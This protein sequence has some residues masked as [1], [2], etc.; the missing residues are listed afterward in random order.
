MV[1]TGNQ[2]PCCPCLILS[3]DLWGQFGDITGSE[4]TFKYI[5]VYSE[6]ST[7]WVPSQRMRSDGSLKLGFQ[8]HA[9]R[10]A[11]A[12]M[13]GGFRDSAL[14]DRF[15]PRGRRLCQTNCW[16]VAGV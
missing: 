15:D 13:V 11:P 6:A 3:S 4:E 9:H 5:E 1:A 7:Y 14:R 16:C 2:H 12:G 10:S 8:I